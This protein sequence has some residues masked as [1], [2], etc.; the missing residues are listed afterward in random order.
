MEHKDKVENLTSWLREAHGVWTAIM[1]AE[2]L[3]I[4]TDLKEINDGRV[5]QGILEDFRK[6][7]L[8]PGPKKGI[9]P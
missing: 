1:E 6:L 2:D 9:E 3:T 4:L 5:V 7:H 8:R